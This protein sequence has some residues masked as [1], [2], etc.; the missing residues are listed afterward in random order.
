MFKEL[1]KETIS[2]SISNPRNRRFLDKVHLQKLMNGGLWADNRQQQ[3]AGKR[4]IKCLVSSRVLES[5]EEYEQHLDMVFKEG[6][7]N[8]KPGR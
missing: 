1:Y 8:K 6:L 5:K 3:E 2:K 7:K 4:G